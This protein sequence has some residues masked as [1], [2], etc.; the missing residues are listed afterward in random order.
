MTAP[1]R[2]VDQTLAQFADHLSQRSATPGGG[3]VAANLAAQGA[4]LAAMAFRFTSG[5]T[6]STVVGDMAR[7]ISEL[8]KLRLRALELVDR[9]SRAYDA[10]SAAYKLP[11]SSDAEKSARTGAIQAAL[12]SAVDVPYETMQTALGALTLCAAGAPDINK[13]L[14]SDCATG[15]LCL[16]AALEGAWL[17]VRINA[18]SIQDAHYVAAH[19]DGGERMRTEARALT[20]RVRSAIEKHLA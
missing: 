3:S 1:S 20:E 16:S 12:R 10:V 2:L 15:A 18:G 19:T 13:N 6:Y 7:R 5:E 9:D 17:N 14:A 11:K 8:D 4:G